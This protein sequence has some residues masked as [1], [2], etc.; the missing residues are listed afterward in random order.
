MIRSVRTCLFKYATFSGRASR[1]EYWWFV[2]F[3]LLVGMAAGTADRIFVMGTGR[4]GTIT[5]LA[6]LILLLPA[7]SVTVRRLHDSGRS[8]WWLPLFYAPIVIVLLAAF[9][10]QGPDGAPMAMWALGIIL[11]S[12]LAMLV[13][14]VALVIFLISRGRQGDNRYGP[15]PLTGQE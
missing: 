14:A 8:G 15:D 11:I 10:G 9:L 5:G 6:T 7:L 3:Q 13:I 2:L 12:G 4:D 1:S